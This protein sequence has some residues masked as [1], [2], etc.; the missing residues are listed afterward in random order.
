MFVKDI[1]ETQQV[2]YSS[3]HYVPLLKNVLDSVQITIKDSSGELVAFKSGS[4]KVILKL[5]FRE[6]NGLQ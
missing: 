3:P 2:T 5:H 1:L 6:K 4:E